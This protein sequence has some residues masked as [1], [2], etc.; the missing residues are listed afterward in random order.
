MD[1]SQGISPGKELD[2]A[3]DGIYRRFIYPLWAESLDSVHRFQTTK[4]YHYPEHVGLSHKK[5]QYTEADSKQ[6]A[7]K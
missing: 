1:I 7:Q 3:P 5:R 2:P 4:E 6:V